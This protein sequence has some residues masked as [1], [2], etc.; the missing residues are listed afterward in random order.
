[1]SRTLLAVVFALALLFSA[2]LEAK[3]FNILVNAE[4]D[5][6]YLERVKDLDYQTYH[7]IR[8]HFFGG[9]TRDK[10][11]ES[12]AFEELAESLAA[13]LKKQSFYPEPDKEK[14]D[15]MIML[16]WGRTATD[17]DYRELQGF[18]NYEETLTQAQREKRDK[19]GGEL[20]LSAPGTPQETPSLGEMF[21][22][23]NVGRSQY[24]GTQFK[25]PNSM[26]IHLL[27]LE[28]DLEM[29]FES[30]VRR[31]SLWDVL[32]EERYFVILNAFDYQHFLEKKELKLVW[33]VRYNTRAVGIGFKKAFE[34]MNDAVSG[35]I[36]LNMDKITTVKGD[37]R[38]S[39]KL[40]DIEVLETG[41]KAEESP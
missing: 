3:R 24:W 39:V 7:F 15:L 33:R 28:D 32:D 8:G 36:G 18:M 16:S 13:T 6:E 9:A 5:E 23:A 35:V 26:N 31:D 25:T 30:T 14:G 20:Q 41:K 2:S 27:G 19:E 10:G 40:G 12:A 11:M 21:D 4:A 34:S 37:T 1:M 38:G 17:P 22:A 29:E